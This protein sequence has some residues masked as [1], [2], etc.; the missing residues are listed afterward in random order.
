MYPNLNAELARR[1]LS[2][3]ELAAQIGR[4]PG[5][6]SLKLS[7]KATLTLPEAARIKEVLGSTLPLEILFSSEADRNSA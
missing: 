3:R 5:T 4:T 1:G 2:R 6:L 7:G